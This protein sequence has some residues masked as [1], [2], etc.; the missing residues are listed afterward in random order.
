MF[1]RFKRVQG[2][3]Y[4]KLAINLM[5]SISKSDLGGRI[6]STLMDEAAGKR[7]LIELVNEG[8]EEGSTYI[9]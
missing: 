8:E 4:I 9:N 3:V 7:K 1:H 5:K 2:T 6:L